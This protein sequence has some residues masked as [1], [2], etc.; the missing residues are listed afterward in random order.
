MFCSNCG[1]ENPNTAKFCAGCGKP[2]AEAAAPAAAPAQ[3]TIINMAPPTQAAYAAPAAA[4]I[5]PKSKTA[6]ALLAFFLGQLGIHRFYVGKVGTG[7]VMLL[8]TIIGY[9]TLSFVVGFFV[10]AVVGIWILVDFI[11]ILMGK[12]KDKN[13]LLISK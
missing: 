5:S 7:I 6:A 1:K 10:L 8:L 11:M 9:A 12:F 2:I 4:G 3:Q 13:G